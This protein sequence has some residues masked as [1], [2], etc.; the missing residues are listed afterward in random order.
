LKTF[1]F[2][3]LCLLLGG[4]ASREAAA[5]QGG[6]SIIR[7][8]RSVIRLETPD[9]LPVPQADVVEWVRRGAVAVR[10]YL[11][12][13][14]V[15][16]LT[17]SVRSGGHE[18]IGGG[19]TYGSS[20]IE[21]T[22]GR[23]VTMAD[24]NGDWVLTHEMFH[25]AFPTL[26]PRYLWMMEGLSDYLEP[27]ARAQAGQWSAVDAWREFVEN[28]PDGLPYLWEKGLDG[29]H[30]RERIYW[31]G[32]IYWLLV[33]LSI[34]EQTQNKRSL[35]DAVRAI[36]DAGGNGSADWPIERV[37]AV[38][39]KATGATALQDWYDKIG[40]KRGDVDL[41]ALWK[42]LGVAET[43]GEIIFDDN[44]PWAMLRASITAPP[45][46]K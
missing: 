23:S 17:V 21:V 8:G 41:A 45:P 42:K 14:P 35:A 36:L 29:T 9:G 33:D 32:N 11:G 20:S 43:N 13:F 27:I 26:E 39:D 12:R 2:A 16:D 31:G 1:V 25:L 46:G 22:L 18:A 38:G 30:R 24:L 7:I 37:L 3:L 44:A 5:G 6:E 10:T 15:E 40:T 19:V 28:F 4:C 34:R